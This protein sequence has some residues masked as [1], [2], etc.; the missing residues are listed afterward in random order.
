MEQKAKIQHK[1]LSTTEIKEIKENLHELEKSL[2]KFKKYYHYDDV[3]YKGIR[4]VGNLFDTSINEDYQKPMSTIDAF[5]NTNNYIECESKRDKN[6]ILSTKEY[7]DMIRPYLSDII[8]DRKTHG[9]WKAQSG[10]K[11]IDYKTQGGWQI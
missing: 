7:L 1:F 10:N 5:N 8:H 11:I 4:R 2:S 6:K 3:E 9:K